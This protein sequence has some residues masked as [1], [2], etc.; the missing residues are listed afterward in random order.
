LC[1]ARIGSMTADASDGAASGPSSIG[2]EAHTIADHSTTSE[3][4]GMIP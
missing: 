4:I 1:A 3:H 2:A